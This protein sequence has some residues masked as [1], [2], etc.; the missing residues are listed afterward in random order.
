MT[1][2]EK[3]ML[4]R[5]DSKIDGVSDSQNKMAVTLTQLATEAKSD[6]ERLSGVCVSV[7]G[8]GKTGLES[9]MVTLETERKAVT[10]G[11]KI[12]WC[13]VITIGMLTA[14]IVGHVLGNTG[15]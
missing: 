12:A 10:T 5:I 7:W 3:R 6:R 14:T 2:E 15:P 8:N 13:V 1:A 4:E 11:V 9:R